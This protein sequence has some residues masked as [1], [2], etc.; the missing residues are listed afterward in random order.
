MTR[1]STAGRLAGTS[2][3]AFHNHVRAVGDRVSAENDRSSTGRSNRPSSADPV[4]GRRTC[5]V[6]CSAS[7]RSGKPCSR[8]QVAESASDADRKGGCC[9]WMV[10]RDCLSGRPGL[11]LLEQGC[12]SFRGRV[13]KDRDVV[14]RLRTFYVCP[15]AFTSV[16]FRSRNERESRADSLRGVTAGAGVPARRRCS[17]SVRRTVSE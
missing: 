13:L 4:G 6:G 9:Q 1:L 5:L 12:G 15:D 2:A 14:R 17:G 7:R 11:W 16:G 10:C 3:T 8:N